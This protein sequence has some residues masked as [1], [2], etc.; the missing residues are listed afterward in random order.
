M[1]GQITPEI[2]VLNVDAKEFPLKALYIEAFNEYF[3]EIS[4]EEEKRT[5]LESLEHILKT[6]PD[7]ICFLSLPAEEEAICLQLIAH[8]LGH[9][10]ALEKQLKK[11]IKEEFFREE[12]LDACER[13]Q[14]DTVHIGG[15]YGKACVWDCARSIADNIYAKQLGDKHPNV[16]YAD[17]AER[18]R[19][20][21][22]IIFEEVTEGY[23]DSEIT[24]NQLA[25]FPASKHFMVDLGFETDITSKG[26]SLYEGEVGESYELF[27]SVYEDCLPEYYRLHTRIQNFLSACDLIQAKPSFWTKSIKTESRKLDT[28]IDTPPRKSSN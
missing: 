15:V 21:N 5:L 28:E 16:R 4:F 2:T 20:K 8:Y 11:Q 23:I 12:F 6:H 3:S 22:A 7:L 26:E 14:I 24:L 1:G 27:S 10:S 17:T 13:E 9:D 18:Y 25:C 19:F